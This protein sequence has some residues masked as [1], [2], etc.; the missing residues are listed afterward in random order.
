[1]S[2]EQEVEQAQDLEQAIDSAAQMAGFED[3]KVE[4][5]EKEME[6]TDQLMLDMMSKAV[7]WLPERTFE[8]S[9]SLADKMIATLE[10]ELEMLRVFN[11]PGN[12]YAMCFCEVD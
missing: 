7:S 5:V 11:D 1:M 2:D 4:F 10:A 12:V 3:P 9:P 8:A 6:F